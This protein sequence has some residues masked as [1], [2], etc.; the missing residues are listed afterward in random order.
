MLNALS[1]SVHGN[2]KLL[3]VVSSAPLEKILKQALH[4]F[5]MTARLQLGDIIDNNIEVGKDLPACVHR[6]CVGGC[7]GLAPLAV[8]LEPVVLL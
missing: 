3:C 7:K 1:Q 5:S 4:V 2:G 8:P 6:A